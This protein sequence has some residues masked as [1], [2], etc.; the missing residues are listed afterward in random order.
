MVLP[1]S[2]KPSCVE[3]FY[4]RYKGLPWTSEEFS[5]YP[6]GMICCIAWSAGALELERTKRSV[7]AF[8]HSV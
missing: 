4:S 8:S 2:A 5:V 7:E 3:A 1:S 6:C